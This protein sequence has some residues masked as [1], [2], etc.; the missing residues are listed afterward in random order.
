MTV[1]SLIRVV[2]KT[3]NTQKENRYHR[4]KLELYIPQI[5]HIYYIYII[6]RDVK[7]LYKYIVRE[8]VKLK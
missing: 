6:E 1:L 3:L 8:D 2:K 4:I 7:L 5:Y